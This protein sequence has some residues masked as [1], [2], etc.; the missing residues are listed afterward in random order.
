VSQAKLLADFSQG[1]TIQ[2]FLLGMKFGA[3]PFLRYVIVF[4]LGILT[5]HFHPHYFRF[6]LLLGVVAFLS[7]SLL[8]TIQSFR[9]KSIKKP[10]FILPFYL[11]LFSAGYINVTLANLANHPD[12][13]L[14]KEEIIK[15]YSVIIS[16]TP[17]EKN[18]SYRVVAKVQQIWNGNKWENAKGK[19]AIYFSKEGY[20][21]ITYGQHL[22]IDGGPSALA[23]PSNPNEFDYRQFLSFQQI[24]HQHF[25]RAGE[26]EIVEGNSGNLIYKYAISLRE[27]LSKELEYHLDDPKIFGVANALLL[28]QKDHLDFETTSAYSAAGAMHVLAVSGLHV[29]IL[30]LMLTYF[31]KGLKKK[32]WGK[33]T[34]ALLS[35]FFLWSFAMLTG[36]SP[37]VLRAATMFSFIVVSDAVGL[38]KN[39]Y[40]TLAASA[41]LLLMIDPYLIMS[42]GFQLSYLAVI[43]IV[44]LQPLIYQVFKPQNKLTKWAWEITAVSVAAQIATFPLGLLYFHQFPSYFIFSNLFVIP[45]AAAVLYSGFFFFISIGLSLL[46]PFEWMILL[47]SKILHY[48]IWISFK[49]VSFVEKL[50]QSTISEVYITILET[51][52]IFTIIFGI[53]IFLDRKKYIGYVITSISII[54]LFVSFTYRDIEDKKVNRLTVYHIS[55]T[56]ALAIQQGKQ[57]KVFAEE[58]IIDDPSR[59]QFHIRP[60]HLRAGFVPEKIAWKSSPLSQ[61]NCILELGSKKLLILEQPSTFEPDEAYFDWVLVRRFDRKSMVLLANIN[62][63]QIILDGTTSVYQQKWLEKEWKNDEIRIHIPYRDNAFEEKF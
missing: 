12:S 54:A 43:G 14:G 8:I 10:L 47:L 19:V 42:V 15:A 3:F 36:L 22:I 59:Y 63:N 55:G 41:F 29:G 53:Y 7:Y 17:A 52:L 48:S 13:L 4:I 51:W 21:E 46:L 60:S 24:F 32:K 58:S 44:S 25:V 61:G 28:G 35:L 11:I 50:P 57:G 2:L 37:S 45:L 23:G 26:Y 16:D 38:R 39:I 9:K 56:S 20:Q 1:Y 33:W 18:K 40:N 30:Y 6:I 31:L 27:Y 34:L 62:T 49:I 5:G